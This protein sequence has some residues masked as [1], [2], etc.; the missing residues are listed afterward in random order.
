MRGTLFGKVLGKAPNLE[1]ARET[2][3]RL[4]CSYGEVTIADMPNGFF[5]VQCESEA[6][7]EDVLADGPW[8]ING[9]VF[10]LLRWKE[11]FEP[12]YEKLTTATL[13]VHL[14]NLPVEYWPPEHLES[15]V[16]Y[17]GKLVKID[18]TTNQKGRACFAR[19]CIELDLTVPLKGGVWVTTPRA[20][21]FVPIRYER[22][23]IF[24]YKC[25]AIGH[26]ATN[27]TVEPSGCRGEASG[28]ESG[29]AAPK[30]KMAM[31]P[32]TRSNQ[33]NTKV[34]GVQ[35]EEVASQDPKK[36]KDG[37][38]G[39]W[40]DASSHRRRG[41]YCGAMTG[42]QSEGHGTLAENRQVNPTNSSGRFACLTEEGQHTGRNNRGN[43]YSPSRDCNGAP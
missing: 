15:L 19:V 29:A 31:P 35:Q 18:N 16:T 36:E 6:M 39:P 13:W 22:L 23:P 41:K 43:G 14:Y 30:G 10:H 27:C 32:K 2:L 28:T 25:G 4:W 11:H 9:S 33:R 24:Y 21:S 1:Y 3:S 42:N 12:M 37:V 20:K 34:P 17:F 5:L 38:Y 40:M 8:T 26:S 7:A